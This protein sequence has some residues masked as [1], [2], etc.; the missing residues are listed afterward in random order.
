MCASASGR[1]IIPAMDKEQKQF[2][3]RLAL[4]GAITLLG[5]LALAA[6][7]TWLQALQ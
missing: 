6:R 4:L 1:L 3:R 7:V 5:F 2:R